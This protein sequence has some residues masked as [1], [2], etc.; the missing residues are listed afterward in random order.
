MVIC[1]LQ[2]LFNIIVFYKRYDY[3]S[4]ALFSVKDVLYPSA[5]DFGAYLAV[6]GENHGIPQ[7]TRADNFGYRMATLVMR[8]AQGVEI[9]C[10]CNTR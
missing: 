4:F 2:Q 9:E 6:G 10:P 3:S 8:R 5:L 7:L 1:F